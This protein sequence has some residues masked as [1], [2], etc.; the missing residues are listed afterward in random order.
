M[1]LPGKMGH[2]NDEQI[3]SSEGACLLNCG[4]LNP[5]DVMLR[6]VAVQV[7]G[8]DDLAYRE[9]GRDRQVF[10]TV[11]FGQAGFLKSGHR[12]R[13]RKDVIPPS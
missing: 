3:A 5:L 2:A 7:F 12:L 4:V 11:G 9:A 1:E 8:S 10:N 13:M 6:H